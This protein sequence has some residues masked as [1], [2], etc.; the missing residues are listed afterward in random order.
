MGRLLGGTISGQLG[1]PFLE[2]SASPLAL[3]DDPLPGRLLTLA[4][5]PG[6]EHFDR[7]ALA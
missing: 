7:G 4:G 2:R 3:R 1:A 5:S 6:V